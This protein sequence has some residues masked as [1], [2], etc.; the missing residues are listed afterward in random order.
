MGLVSKLIV[1][2]ADSDADVSGQYVRFVIPAVCI[3]YQY[4]PRG[5]SE[6]DPATVVEALGRRRQLPLLVAAD[7]RL[8]RHVLHGVHVHMRTLT[9]SAHKDPVYHITLSSFWQKVGSVVVRPEPP[10]LTIIAGAPSDVPGLAR[11]ISP[12]L[13][14]IKYL[15]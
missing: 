3:H 8:P 12:R 11:E 4:L 1:L 7:L 14:H 6:R 15:L 13:I 2:C 5:D 9:R 10:R